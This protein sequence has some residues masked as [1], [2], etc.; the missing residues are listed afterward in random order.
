MFV[1]D[2]VFVL[3]KYLIMSN[4]YKLVCVLVKKIALFLQ[5]I[6]LF[7][8]NR[9]SPNYVWLPANVS[10]GLNH[11]N[12]NKKSWHFLTLVIC[13][14]NT[15]GTIDHR[16]TGQVEAPLRRTGIRAMIQIKPLI[17]LFKHREA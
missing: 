8:N 10:S 15:K 14:S 13:C 4:W 6:G 7:W 9:H 12:C 16:C 17:P 2:F 11:T 5:Q 3:I 1:R